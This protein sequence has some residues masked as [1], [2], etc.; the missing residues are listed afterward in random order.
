MTGRAGELW[1]ALRRIP[2]RVE[3]VVRARLHCRLDL[4]FSGLPG[5][6]TG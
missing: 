3:E 1:A 5:S 6:E 4:Q 2:E